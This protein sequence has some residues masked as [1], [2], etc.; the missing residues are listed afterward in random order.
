MDNFNDDFINLRQ[1]VFAMHAA[2]T[3]QTDMLSR[4]A[5][6]FRKADEGGR[7]EITAAMHRNGL[8]GELADLARMVARQEAQ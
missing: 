2:S 4:I 1:A 5:E 3:R 7:A 8:S 6:R